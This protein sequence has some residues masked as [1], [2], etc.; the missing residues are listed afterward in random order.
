MEYGNVGIDFQFVP[1]E[2]FGWVNASYRVG[3]RYLQ[4]RHLIGLGA[5]INRK[6]CFPPLSL[7]NKMRAN[8]GRLREGEVLEFITLSLFPF[9]R[10]CFRLMVKEISI[11]VGANGEFVGVAAFISASQP[12]SGKPV[13]ICFYT[14]CFNCTSENWIQI[15]RVDTLDKCCIEQHCLLPSVNSLEDSRVRFLL[16]SSGVYRVTCQTGS[17]FILQ[18]HPVV[19]FSLGKS[20]MMHEICLQTLVPKWMG[21]IS[22][23]ERHF[24]K[25]AASGFNAVYLLPF[26]EFGCSG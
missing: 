23:W 9:L 4:K 15:E 19:H 10:G 25:L 20:I 14:K 11:E 6:S 24:E 7:P 1:K 3:Q 16:G 5:L 17:S 18:I 13:R 2:G 12:L 21:E 26:Q 22:E 8:F